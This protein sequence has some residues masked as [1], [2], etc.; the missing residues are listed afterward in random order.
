MEFQ[1]TRIIEEQDG[2]LLYECPRCGIRPVPRRWVE[3]FRRCARK[4][5]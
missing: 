2:I 5:G 1:R 4:R 3:R